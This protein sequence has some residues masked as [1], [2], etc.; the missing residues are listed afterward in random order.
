MAD[1]GSWR[2]T[3][4]FN[5]RPI[6]RK[7]LKVRPFPLPIADPE[8]DLVRDG[9]PFRMGDAG[10][11]QGDLPFRSSPVLYVGRWLALRPGRRGRSETRR[12]AV[13]GDPQDSLMWTKRLARQK[14]LVATEPRC[15]SRRRDVYSSRSQTRMTFVS[16]LSW[17]TFRKGAV[18]T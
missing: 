6:G 14:P 17:L 3:D 5:F 2:A 10:R 7:S 15:R 1:A 13:L 9:D 18:S 16:W 12:T 8:L 4:L 11:G